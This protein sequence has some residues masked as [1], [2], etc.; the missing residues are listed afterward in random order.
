VGGRAFAAPGNGLIP[1][2]RARR[3][4]TLHHDFAP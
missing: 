3:T 4:C 2:G 1:S